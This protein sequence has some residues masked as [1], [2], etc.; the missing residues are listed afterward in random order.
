MYEK[1]YEK[2]YLSVSTRAVIGQFS[3]PYSA[4]QPAKLTNQKFKK[5]LRVQKFKPLR[6][7][8]NRSRTRQTHKRD[9]YNK[10]SY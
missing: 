10:I 9:I 3:G 8:R 5:Y 6:V 7:N 1:L 2:L 4:I